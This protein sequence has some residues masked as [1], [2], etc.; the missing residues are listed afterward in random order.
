MREGLHGN[1]LL[2]PGKRGQGRQRRGQR[3]Q[4]DAVTLPQHIERVL[5]IV[6]TTERRLPGFV[7]P[8]GPRMMA[9]VPG[10]APVQPAE[11]TGVVVELESPIPGIVERGHETSFIASSRD[12]RP[13]SCP[14]AGFWVNSL[15]ISR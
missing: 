14:S 15:K 11:P 13:R 3:E 1:F 7:Q 6:S 5:G 9:W 10:R 2:N 4:S 8:K 12:G